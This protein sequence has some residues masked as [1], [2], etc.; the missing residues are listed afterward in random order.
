MRN[1][2]H[3]VKA[4]QLLR[5]ECKTQVISTNILV[6]VEDNIYSMVVLPHKKSK[7]FSKLVAAL[8]QGYV[9]NEYIRSY[10]EGNLSEMQK[11][12]V[13]SLDD[14]LN[15]MTQSLANIG[16]YTGEMQATSSKGMQTF[17]RVLEREVQEK[18]LPQAQAQIGTSSAEVE[19][20]KDDISMLKKQNEEILNLLRSGSFNQM[21]EK[22]RTEVRK[23][24]PKKEINPI[25]LEI[26]DFTPTLSLVSS[27]ENT[28]EPEIDATEAMNNLLAGNSF[29]F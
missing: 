4:K 12:A 1:I 24:L 2:K 25:N 22:G 19:E 29:S 10:I 3:I 17:N 23:E 21:T 26:E 11:A 15:N 27:G 14:V 6:E 16:L 5:R 7:T 20:L 9:E 13:N 28:S 8:I 18:Q